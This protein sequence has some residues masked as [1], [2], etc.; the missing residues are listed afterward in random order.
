MKHKIFISLAMAFLLII[1]V[2]CG[3]NNKIYIEQSDDISSEDMVDG[4]ESGKEKLTTDTKEVQSETLSGNEADTESLCEKKASS[5]VAEQEAYYVYVCGAVCTPGVYVLQPGE[6]IYE[7]IAQAGGLTDEASAAVV[8]Q[9]EQVCDGQMIFVPT[10]EEAAAGIFSAAGA[11]NQLTI[12]GEHTLDDRVDLNTA[13]LNE[14]MTLPGIGESK[15]QG[16][17]AYRSSKGAFSSVEEIM[18]VDGIKE[19]LYNR[20]KD[21][22]KVN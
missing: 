16:I 11:E 22:I 12:G 1:S 8:N 9:A 6:R 5:A 17:L 3:E 18:N 2:G 10:K 14:L 7:A 20:I 13:S 19:G 21:S 4:T 15:A